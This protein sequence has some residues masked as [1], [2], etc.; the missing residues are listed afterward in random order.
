MWP[1]SFESP[2]LFWVRMNKCSMGPANTMEAT[3]AWVVRVASTS[4]RKPGWLPE[5]EKP[6]ARRYGWDMRDGRAAKQLGSEKALR[7]LRK[8][9]ARVF[10]QIKW[11]LDV[12]PSGN[13]F[14]PLEFTRETITGKRGNHQ[15]LKRHLT[16]FL[17]IPFPYSQHTKGGKGNKKGRCES[18][19][20]APSL[21][22]VSPCQSLDAAERQRGGKD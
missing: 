19:G 10:H 14:N 15:H 7:M 16:P 22:Q 12:C 1:F 4:C 2:R 3:C 8:E 21:L 5:T 17:L 11:H 9:L 18:G 20:T 6:A 13:V